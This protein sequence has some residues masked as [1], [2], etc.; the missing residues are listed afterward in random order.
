MSLIYAGVTD[1]RQTIRLSFEGLRENEQFYSVTP[2]KEIPG[3]RRS[4]E[5]IATLRKGDFYGKKQMFIN[6]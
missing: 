6:Q 3:E 5:R 2:E 1:I 4:G